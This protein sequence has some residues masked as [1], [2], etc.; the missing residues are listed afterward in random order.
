MRPRLALIGIVA[1]LAVAG[2]GA[3]ATVNVTISKN[4]YTPK[5]VTIGV[6]DSVQFANTDTV[7]HQVLFKPTTGVACTPN[8]LVL[9]AGQSGSCTFGTDG[10]YALSDPNVK[11][12]AFQGTITVKK[13]PPAGAVSLKATP[14]IVVYGGKVT[15]SGA[16]KNAK[17]GETVKVSA[18]PCGTTASAATVTS[19]ATTA[20]GAFSVVVQ[21]LQNTTYN[22]AVMGATSKPAAVQVRPRIQL[23]KVA[24]HHRY[25]ARV[26]AA[27]GFTGKQASFQRYSATLRRWVRVRKV[28]L[29]AASAGAAPTVVTTAKFRSTLGA[30]RLV[31]LAIA[32]VNSAACYLGGIS[33]TLRS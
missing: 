28:T 14:P 6:G 13:P 21:P 26:L 15:L 24:P 7:V 30:G 3:A 4:G 17:A 33:N 9:Q 10:K 20:N 5:A 29:G 32:Q 22:A 16:L 27:T 2:A 12:K 1:A 19:A 11:G 25:S 31:R 8:P 23:K 18:Q